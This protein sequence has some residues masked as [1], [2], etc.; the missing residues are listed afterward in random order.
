MVVT[1][2]GSYASPRSHKA[3]RIFFSLTKTQEKFE[4][5]LL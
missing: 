4:K 2:S 5:K 1:T 3:I